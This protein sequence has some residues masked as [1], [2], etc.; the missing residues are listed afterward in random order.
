[1]FK[2]LV[3]E[4]EDGRAEHFDKT[5]IGVPGKTLVA[6]ELCQ[7]PKPVTKAA[8]LLPGTKK[9]TSITLLPSGVNSFTGL[10]LV[11]IPG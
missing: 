5:A 6:G 3:V 7:A 10:K 2:D 9:F 11:K 8:T 4:I 1:V